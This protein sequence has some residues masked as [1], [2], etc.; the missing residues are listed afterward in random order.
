VGTRARA[1][2]DGDAVVLG[3]YG[4]SVAQAASGLA[5]SIFSALLLLP[6]ALALAG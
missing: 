5:L 2:P 4:F 1:V 6:V 3:L